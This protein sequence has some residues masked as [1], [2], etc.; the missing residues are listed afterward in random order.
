MGAEPRQIPEPIRH[1]LVVGGTGMLAG[2]V[3]VLAARGW[4]VSVLARGRQGLDELERLP[5][6]TAVQ[7]DYR[8]LPA[9]EAAIRGVLPVDLVVAWIHSTAPQ[10]PLRLAHMVADAQ[11]PVWYYHVLGSSGGFQVPAVADFTSVSGLRYHQIALGYARED[12]VSR[13][14]THGEIAAGVMRAIDDGSPRSIVGQLE[15]WSRRP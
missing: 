8:D 1:A 10:A 9:F 13:W 3:E 15:P 7:A 2:V 4:R 12:G 11:R 14:L 6:V 5:G